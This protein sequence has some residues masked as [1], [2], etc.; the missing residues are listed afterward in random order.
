[1]TFSLDPRLEADSA[2]VCDLALCSVRLMNDARFAWLVLVPRH[3]GL[4]EIADLSAGDRARLMEE[5]VSRANM[6]AAYQRVMTNKGAAGIDRMTVEQLQPYLKE[7]WLRIKEELLESRYWP[8]PVRGVEIPK[9][10]GGMRQLGIPTH[11]A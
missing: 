7:H 4:V 11:R 8:Q 6:M 10:G 2:P 3:D 5:I 9:P 1:M